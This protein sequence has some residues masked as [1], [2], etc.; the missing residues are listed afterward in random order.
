M[1]CYVVLC[2]V[3]YEGYGITIRLR[4]KPLFP[5]LAT[6]PA[7]FQISLLNM[8]VHELTRWKRFAAKGGIGKCTAMHDCVAQSTD[9]L[10][11]LKVRSVALVSSG[12]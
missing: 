1:W 11:F 2:N 12:V 7:T 10:M 8:N 5:D 4:T 3:S 6:H 9:D